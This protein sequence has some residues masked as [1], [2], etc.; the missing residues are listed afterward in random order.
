MAGVTN[1]QDHVLLVLALVLVGCPVA[2]APAPA[3]RWPEPDDLPSECQAYCALECGLDVADCEARCA[4][5]VQKAE[6]TYGSTC[7]STVE[8]TL[9][10]WAQVGCSERPA[11]LL[12]CLPTQTAQPESCGG[13]QPFFLGWEPCHRECDRLVD[14]CLDEFEDLTFST[15]EGCFIDCKTNMGL[16]LVGGCFEVGYSFTDILADEPCSPISDA[17]EAALEAWLTCAESNGLAVP[18]SLRLVEAEP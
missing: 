10:C 6:D 2:P 1:R 16:D 5:D 9:A 13:D 14:R 17:A 3:D 15:W 8:A 11:G 7:R 4:A 18:P 12:E